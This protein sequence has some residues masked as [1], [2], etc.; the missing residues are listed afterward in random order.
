MDAP[1]TPVRTL[2]AEDAGRSFPLYTVWEITMKCDQPCGHCG[3]RAGRARP[4]ELT[5]EE[6]FE[7]ADA[8]ARL[9]TREVTLIGGEAYLREDCE[10]IIRRLAGHGMRVTMQ[11]GGRAFT[12]DRARRFREAGLSALGVSIDGLPGAHDKLRG[13]LGSHAAAMRALRNAREVGMGLAVSTQVNRLSMPDLE[14][15][16][17]R[18]RAEGVEVWQLQLTGPL[19][20][21]ADRP[22]W[23]LQ[24]W[25]IVPVIDTL[26]KI[27]LEA[28]EEHR[29]AGG[30]GVAFN[31][32]ANNNVGY[33]GPHEQVIRSRPGGREAHFSGCKAGIYV[34]GIESDGTVKACPTLPTEGY[35][36]GNVREMS[37]ADLWDR[38]GRMRFSRDRDTGEL[39]GHCASCYYAE[40]CKAGCSWTTHTFFGK[41]GNM[42]FCYHRVTQLKKKG[43]RERVVK[44]EDAPGLPYDHGKFAIVEEPWPEA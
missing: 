19:G 38:Q 6:S 5:T 8:L 12:A 31:V 29:A 3:S 15:L 28:A 9:G 30:K 16:G 40:T 37:L 7:V 1:P 33:F 20:R 36:A 35:R 4:D 22:E 10:A 23:L 34:L 13:N 24:P 25:E 39:W 14:E 11:T 44:V 18:L 43:I 17:R 21:A 2:R 41:R 27:Q 26:A 42:P 32:F